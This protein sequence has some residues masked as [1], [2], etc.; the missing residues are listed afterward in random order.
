MNL[1]CIAPNLFQNGSNGQKLKENT[2]CYIKEI[3]LDSN[4][5]IRYT[6]LDS[7]STRKEIFVKKDL[8]DGKIESFIDDRRAFENLSINGRYS[9]ENKANFAT[10]A[11]KYGKI[12]TELLELRMAWK[13][14]L[15]INIYSP[16]PVG[17]N[18]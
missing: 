7:M 1:K 5:I 9:V 13:Y 18:G 16:V 8:L 2:F 15:I 11:E 10:L 6:Q 4:V 14:C 12:A 17:I 3:L